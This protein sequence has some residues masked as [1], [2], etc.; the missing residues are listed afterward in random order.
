MKQVSSRDN[1]A[2]KLL[3]RLCHSSRDR[4][5]FGKCVLEGAHT[6][7]AYLDRFGPPEMLVLSEAVLERP[8]VQRLA[9]RTAPQQVIVATAR[10]FEE[11]AQTPAPSGVIA[12]I[13][14]PGAHSS[15]PGPFNILLDG[16]QD[17]GNVGT[18][19]RSAAA[20]GVSHAFLSPDSAFAWSPKVLRAAQGAHF[21]LDIVEGAD[22]PSLAR[23]FE[24]TV[25][26][27][28]PAGGQT[29]FDADLCGALMLLVG[30]EGA[31]I[32]ADLLAAATVRV[33]I[34]MPGGF[35]SLNAASAAAICLF[36]K[37]RQEAVRRSP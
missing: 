9:Q 24:G 17:P 21:Y 32:S 11:L 14:A 18:I 30:N 4:R 7:A 10:L 26:A 6:I 22:L 33:T 16:V 15:A 29:V 34:P 5:K 35:E 27:A 8:E 2:W 12:V 13:A 31:G 36:E 1:P 3:V 20:A 23:S 19:L 37:V 28:A 25:V